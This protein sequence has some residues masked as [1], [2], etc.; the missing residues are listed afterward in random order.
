MRKI[1]KTLLIIASIGIFSFM[2]F[3]AF[4]ILSNQDKY[5]QKLEKVKKDSLEQKDIII[6]ENKV[7]SKDTLFLKLS[8]DKLIGKY[9]VEWIN[10][11]RGFYLKREKPKTDFILYSLNF[12]K[13]GTIEFKNLTEF[14]D[15]GNGILSL[16]NIVFK[17][18]ERK[19]YELEFEGE[20]Y[21]ETRFKVKGE[22][23][24]TETEKGEKYLHLIDLIK[25]ERTEYYE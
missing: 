7:K 18:N 17:Y 10:P 21:L 15:C 22:Y 16:K 25:Y 20:Y 2:I 3:F 6:T 9:Y 8:N 23:K 14:Y 4:G 24:F 13:N 11:K 12:K 19:N 1:L 5:E